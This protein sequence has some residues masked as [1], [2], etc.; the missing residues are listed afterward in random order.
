M[1]DPRENTDWVTYG[2]YTRGGTAPSLEALEEQLAAPSAVDLSEATRQANAA[3]QTGTKILCLTGE[4]DE[5][6]PY[7]D[8]TRAYARPR[9]WE[10]YADKHRGVSL[11]FDQAAL[12][13][14]V[15]EQLESQGRWWHGALQ[16]DNAALVEGATTAFRLDGNAILAEGSGDLNAGLVAHIDEHYQ[17]LFFTKMND[18]RDEQEIRYV[19][20]DGTENEFAWVDYGDALVAIVLGEAFPEDLK[21]AAAAACDEHGVAIRQLQWTHYNPLAVPLS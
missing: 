1:R 17:L 16:Y 4:P 13:D 7:E 9:M 6:S 15:A 19:L 8:F 10:Q 14:I 3:R 21:E 5:R 11:V 2:V 18:Y 20:Y 12:A